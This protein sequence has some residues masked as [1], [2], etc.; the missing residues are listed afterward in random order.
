MPSHY[1]QL[2]I[3]CFIGLTMCGDANARFFGPSNAAECIFE[4]IE[5]VANDR[6][7]RLIE[8]N[9]HEEFPGTSKPGLFGVSDYGQCVD[10]HMS[11]ALSHAAAQIIARTCRS[12]FAR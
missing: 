9:C 1:R 7:A 2:A 11:K 10:M 3:I 12:L 8:Q 5:G 6:E 4:K